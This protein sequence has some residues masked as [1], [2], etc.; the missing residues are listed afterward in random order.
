MTHPLLRIVPHV[1][2]FGF[3]FLLVGC[4]QFPPEEQPPPPAVTVSYPLERDVTDTIDFTGRTAAVDQVK[5]QARVWGSLEKI[6]FV[7]GAEVKKGDVLF[8]IDQ[9]PYNAALERAEAD[10]AQS[11]AHKKRLEADHG[12]AL[13]LLG[14]KAMAREEYDKMNGDLSEAQAAVRSA[15]AMRTIAKLN[16]D[17]TEVRAPIDGQVG[18]A[19]VTVGNLVQSGETAGTLLTT[20]VSVD[21]MWAYFDVDDHT[22]LQVRD[23]VRMVKGKATAGGLPPVLLGLPNEPGLPHQGTIDF[24][25]NQVDPGTGTVRL[26]GVFPNKDRSLTPG[27][28]A[29]IRMPLGGRHKAL[30]V[31][32]RAIDTDQGEKVV[33]VVNGDNKVERRPVQ[34][35]GLHEGLREIASGVQPGEHVVVEGIQRVRPDTPVQP[36]LKDMPELGAR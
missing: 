25:D 1:A 21:P 18:R 22:F 11:E 26:R 35:K 4:S 34:L 31:S 32:D 10:V 29:R 2:A 8:V 30:L 24:V 3:A 19:L 16:L 13:I 28:L 36:T 5:V 20:I 7:E 12:R 23:L 15:W 9:R 14:Q 33:Y 17:F 6:N 27:L